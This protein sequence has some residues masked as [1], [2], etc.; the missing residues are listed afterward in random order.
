MSTLMSACTHGSTPAKSSPR[1]LGT[2]VFSAAGRTI[3]VE[4]EIARTPEQHQRGLMF[5][6][7]LPARKGMLFLYDHDDRHSFWMKNTYIPLDMI[8]I[9]AEKKVVGI[10][11]HAEP[12]T[13]THRQVDTPSRYIV[14]VNAGFARTNNIKAGVRVLFEGDGI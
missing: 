2:V 3:R 1:D 4:V 5:R 9:S 14:E 8:F 7:H 6:K 12:M 13:E 10:V 11:E